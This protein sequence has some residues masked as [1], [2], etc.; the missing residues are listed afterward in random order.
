MK[1][2]YY[3]K[4]ELL[5]AG[6]RYKRQEVMRLK[7]TLTPE[8]WDERCRLRRAKQQKYY[9]QRRRNTAEGYAER[10]VERARQMTKDT[11]L[12]FE[13]VLNLI[14]KGCSVTGR[15]FIY[16]NPF[17]SKHNP[18]APS[19]DQVIPKGGYYKSNIQIMCSCIN[20]FKNDLQPEDFKIVWRALTNKKD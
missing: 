16:E 12:T 19:I 1:K 18:Y 4:E 7:A 10:L 3:T 5:E 11:D 6:R 15:P 14:H 8:E 2:L 13:Y 20:R 9:Q 17:S